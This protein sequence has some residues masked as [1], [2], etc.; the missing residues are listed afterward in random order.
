[1]ND[2]QYE[3]LWRDLCRAIRN[4]D[5]IKT[6]GYDSGYGIPFKIWDVACREETV[7]S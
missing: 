1:M 2:E 5:E 3:Q 7:R 6:W 4:E